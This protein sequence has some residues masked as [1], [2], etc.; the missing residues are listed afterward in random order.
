M[1][2]PGV[3]G[4][5]DRIWACDSSLEPSCHKNDRIMGEFRFA[6]AARPQCAKMCFLLHKAP[7]NSCLE[8]CNAN[9][10]VD[11]LGKLTFPK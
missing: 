3:L 7:L 5:F 8:G 2:C 1:F 11:N 4:G 9:M 10:I 6:L